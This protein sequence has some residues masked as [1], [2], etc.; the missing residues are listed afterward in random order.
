MDTIT[1]AR[2]STTKVGWPVLMRAQDEF[3][4]SGQAELGQREDDDQRAL[5][6]DA[7]VEDQAQQQEVG[8]LNDPAHRQPENGFRRE[9]YGGLENEQDECDDK[10]HACGHDDH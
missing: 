7:E 8:D 1:R 3:E 4:V 5:M 10:Q 9:G 6:P 2:L